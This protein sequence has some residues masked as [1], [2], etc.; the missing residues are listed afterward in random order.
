MMSAL[1]RQCQ[2]RREAAGTSGLK[3]GISAQG[4]N[5]TGIRRKNKD[6]SEKIALFWIIVL[7]RL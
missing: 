5:V 4:E 3:R 2:P 6:F 7:W 1:S